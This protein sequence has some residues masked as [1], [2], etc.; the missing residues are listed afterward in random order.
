V[1]LMAAAL[2]AIWFFLLRSPRHRGRA[3]GARSRR[4]SVAGPFD[5]I[6]AAQIASLGLTLLGG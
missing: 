4:V 6:P 3:S 5:S 1:G 2:L